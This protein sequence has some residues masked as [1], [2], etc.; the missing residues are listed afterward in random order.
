M[1]VT[2][3][4]HSPN[5]RIPSPIAPISEV[6]LKG[7]TKLISPVLMATTLS[8]VATVTDTAAVIISNH[9]AKSTSAQSR[10]IS[11]KAAKIVLPRAVEKATVTVGML[12]SSL[13]V[14]ISLIV[15]KSTA[16]RANSE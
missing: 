1:K 8:N 11:I 14:D 12:L 15:N 13:R 5:N 16:A 7:E 6:Y 2:P 3:S 9:E 10:P 4:G